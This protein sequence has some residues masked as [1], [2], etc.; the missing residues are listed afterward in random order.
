MRGRDSKF[1][2][3]RIDLG[4]DGTC[5]SCGRVDAVSVPAGGD[6][7]ARVLRRHK[8]PG[9]IADPY[10]DHCSGSRQIRVE[11]QR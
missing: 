2:P 11:D 4:F 3:E 7:S 9:S 10:I 5:P 8:T 6:G 1:A